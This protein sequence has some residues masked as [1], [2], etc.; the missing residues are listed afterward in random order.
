MLHRRGRD[1]VREAHALDLLLGLERAGLGEQRCRVLDTGT[2]GGEPLLREGRRFADHA[3]GSLRAEGEL[4]ADRLVL[5]AHRLRGLEHAGDRGSRVAGVVAREHPD[6][7][8]PGRASRI[9]L[10]RLEAD[11]DR[12]A[13]AREDARVVSLHAPEVREVEDVVGRPHDERVEPPLG[14]ER[15]DAVE[16]RIVARPA[17][18]ASSQTTVPLRVT[19]RPM[20]E[21]G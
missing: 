19:M 8:G 11:E 16:L 1:L 2:E 13:L 17:Q 9:L 12:L 20:P 4:E 18:A 7:I 21:P 15:A 5:A 10:G 6:V 3:I 14:H